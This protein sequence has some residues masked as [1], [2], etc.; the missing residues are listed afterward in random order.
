[1]AED[2]PID[3]RCV[4]SRTTLSELR[5]LLDEGSLAVSVGR[6]VRSVEQSMRVEGYP[7]SH[8]AALSAAERVLQLTAQTSE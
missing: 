3:D 6:L 7:V 4:S 5:R 1:M 2:K 8:T